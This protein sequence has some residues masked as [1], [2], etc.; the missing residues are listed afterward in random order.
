MVKIKKNS[1]ALHP[2]IFIFKYCDKSEF[3]KSYN[4]VNAFNIGLVL[5]TYF[6]FDLICR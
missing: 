6:K 3:E 1:N 2:A 4:A 5:N